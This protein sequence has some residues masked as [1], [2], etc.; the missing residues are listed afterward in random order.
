MTLWLALAAIAV[1]L[2][3]Q[4]IIAPLRHVLVPEREA[5]EDYTIVVPL[6]GA[7]SY[8][9]N[10][11][12]IEPYR[13][14]VLLAIDVRRAPM[15]RLADELERDG[16]RVRRCR[17][18][19]AS[20]PA[21]VLLALSQVTTEYV[22]RLDGDSWPADDP[23]RAIAAA[24]RAEADVC[25]VRVVPSRRL[26]IAE[27]LQGVEY[28]CAMRGRRLRPWLT[29][30]ACIIARATSM[31]TLL[32]RHSRW[33]AG[34]D[35]E[36]GVLARC[37]GLRIHHVDLEVHTE[38]PA[39][40][41]ALFG[42]RQGWWAGSFR[43]AWINFDRS[44]HAP[45]TLFYTAVLV[46]LGLAGKLVTLLTA[47]EV[48]PLVILLYTAIMVGSNWRIRNRWM[49]LYPYYALVQSLVL[50]ALGV[51][52][53]LQMARR[54]GNLGRYRVPFRPFAWGRS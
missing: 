54:H 39:G 52:R 47:A 15:R 25:S 46:W 12:E 42:Q 28:D 11:E 5:S 38:V 50:P 36:T 41:R 18:R 9:R 29:S 17:P 20:P 21:L 32:R 34:E 19:V 13:S 40:F 51:V 24:A 2:D 48:L 35:V 27:H 53:Y 37:Y 23:G 3:M 22:V 7:P 49:I 45:I 44:L 30:G 31:R 4:N 10:R 8:F 33:F 16:W 1:G 14:H 43:G 26:T 6:F